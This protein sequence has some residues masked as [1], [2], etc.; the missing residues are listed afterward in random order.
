L[1]SDPNAEIVAQA[2]QLSLAPA[3]LLTGVASLLGIMANRL[4]RVIDR[5]R[6]VEEKWKSLD[7]AGRIAAR[8]EIATLEQRRKL[9]SWAINFA[10]SA[11]LLVSLVI[12]T[13]FFEEYFT[14]RLRWLA[15]ALFVA[16]MLAVICGLSFFLREVS[17][18]ART[19]RIDLARFEA[20]P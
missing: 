14:T 9:C 17:L 15:G 1:P 4:A 6:S 20:Q 16:G 2:I 13:L 11:A 10:T 7:E 12:V 5:A 19:T 8:L 18:A 3:F